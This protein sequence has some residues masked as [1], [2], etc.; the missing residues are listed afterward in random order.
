L[1][2]TDPATDYRQQTQRLADAV[3]AAGALALKTF[4]APLK[5]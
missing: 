3:R 1:P 2:D 4:R 5:S